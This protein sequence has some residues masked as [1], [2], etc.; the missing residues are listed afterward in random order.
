MF[1]QFVNNVAIR[2]GTSTNSH[3][4]TLWSAVSGVE[5]SGASSGATTHNSTS[6]TRIG[7]SAT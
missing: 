4:T 3:R 5:G 6:H 7:S 1:W 2:K